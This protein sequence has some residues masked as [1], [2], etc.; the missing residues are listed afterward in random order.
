MPLE[1]V[2]GYDFGLAELPTQEKFFLQARGVSITGLE[3]INLADGI[4]GI[5]TGDESSSTNSIGSDDIGVIWVDQ[6][7]DVWLRTAT[8]PVRMVKSMCGWESNRY[9]N[10]DN[11][12]FGQASRGYPLT[13]LNPEFGRAL[14]DDFDRGPGVSEIGSP[15]DVVNI[16]HQDLTMNQGFANWYDGIFQETTVSGFMRWVGR[17]GTTFQNINASTHPSEVWI[18][19]YRT[20]V[21]TSG[22]PTTKTWEPQRNVTSGLGKVCGL[23]LG[24]TSESSSVST[25]S[26]GTQGHFI[27]K[28]Q[29]GYFFGTVQMTAL[30]VGVGGV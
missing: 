6:A 9:Y 19:R 25:A 27:R 10:R 5:L 11:P 16:Q 26:F 21:T 12:G 14:S 30:T 1:I 28:F 18:N 15:T 4:S 8:G 13:T 22:S 24:P 29:M 2:P 20:Y 3:S 17:G 23:L 7:N